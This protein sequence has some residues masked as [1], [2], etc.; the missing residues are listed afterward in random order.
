M[1]DVKLS[2]RLTRDPELK[3]T[4]NGVPVATFALAVDR[5][6]NREEADFIPVTTWRKTAEFVAKY[7]RKGQRVIIASGGSGSTPTLTRTGTK[8]PASKW[9]PTKSSSRNPAAPQRISR[10]GA[11]PPVTWRTRASQRLTGKTVNFPSDARRKEGE[12]HGRQRKERPRGP[13]GRRVYDILKNHD[14]KCRLLKRRSTQSAPPWKKTWKQSGPEPTRAASDMIR[15]ASQSS[16]DP[17]GLL[18]KVADAI[19]RRTARTKRATDALEERQRQIENVH[20]AILTMDAKSKIILL[21]LYYPRR[22]YAQAAELLDMDV[23]TV[24]RQRKTAVDRLVRKY[25]RLHGNIE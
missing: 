18:V 19:Q 5:K 7:F 12:R 13:D 8:E 4:P 20:E 16:P 22:T 23:S 17:D 2:G 1:N 15:P 9:W 10:P 14:R 25:I 24:S 3:Q 11:W 21:T 6:F